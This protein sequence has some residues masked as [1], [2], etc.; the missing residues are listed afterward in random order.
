MGVSNPLF[1]EEIEWE[2]SRST[3][4]LISAGTGT[5]ISLTLF[6]TFVLIY[7]PLFVFLRRIAWH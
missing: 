6:F 5:T 2:K 4:L 1:E 7:P 3:Y